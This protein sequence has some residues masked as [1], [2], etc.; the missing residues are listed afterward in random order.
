MILEEK[1]NNNAGISNF[2]VLSDSLFAGL[3]SYSI[4][5]PHATTI[6]Q[7]KAATTLRK[8]VPPPKSANMRITPSAKGKQ[9]TVQPPQQSEKHEQTRTR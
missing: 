1:K 5:A 9:Q 6:S 3:P 4:K 7:A 8:K 2:P